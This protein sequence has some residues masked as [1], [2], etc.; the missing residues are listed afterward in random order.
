MINLNLE[1]TCPEQVKIKTFLENNASEI[2]ADKIING[3]KIEKNGKT[4]INK[5]NLTTFYTPR[6]KY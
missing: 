5:K 4:L 3:V 1:T 6:K 2:L